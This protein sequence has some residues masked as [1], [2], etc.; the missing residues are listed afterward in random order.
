MGISVIPIFEV[1]ID[2]LFSTARQVFTSTSFK[3]SLSSP[4][5][6]VGE[7]SFVKR[8]DIRETQQLDFKELSQL[9]QI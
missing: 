5:E 2:A 9:V 3:P 7:V 4:R 8:V 6:P 1:S